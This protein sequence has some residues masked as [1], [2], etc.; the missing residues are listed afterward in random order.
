MK[1]LLKLLIQE[2]HASELPT[3][4]PRELN[5][6]VFPKNVR[7]AIVFTG[8]RR[9]GK[10]WMMFQHIRDLLQKGIKKEQILYLNFED[11]R[12]ANFK[13]ENFQEILDAYYDLFPERIGDENVYFYVDEIHVV[14][15]WEKFIRRLIDQEK[16]QI[17][18]TG[19]SAKMLSKELATTLR[20]RAI[21][22]EVFPFSYE[23]YLAYHGI[24][25]QIPI[26]SKNGS[27]LRNHANRYLQ[28]GG[29]P[30]TLNLSPE[31][32][33]TVIQE[34]MHA[35]VFR[36]VVE[37]YEMKNV[38]LVKI[39]LLRCLQQLSSLLSITKLYNGLKSE[40]Y[41][42]GKNSLFDL[43]DYFEEAYALFVVPIFAF[44]EQKR[45]TNPKKLYAV[46]PGIITAY[47][48]KSEFEKSSTLE[49]SVFMKLRRETE[50]IFYYKT[51]EGR[52]IDFV[53][54]NEQGGAC[55]FQV[56]VTI[57]SPDTLEREVRALKE[58]SIELG[59]KECW[60]IT[61]D[62]EQEISAEDLRI[63][64]VP[65]WKWAINR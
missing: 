43:L 7:K 65:F 8:M 35:V 61:I 33:R 34:Y 59:L 41:S 19:S 11:D 38:P 29:F 51:K 37:R 17:F 40:G 18:V 28:Y 53:T 36:D 1:E 60:L 22:R 47:T 2:F 55:L 27:I 13:T 45:Q 16:M 15:G 39:F 25:K 4:F 6:P 24:N 20:G 30:E 44:S 10:T 3:P 54:L 31:L 58:A 42:V 57:D 48:M 14:N 64:C 12:L 9:T 21:S 63:H 46:D 50:Q 49:N 32:H 26:T 52:E 23:E 5:L 56:A 62:H